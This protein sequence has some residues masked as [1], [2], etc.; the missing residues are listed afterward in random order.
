MIPRVPRSCCA[1][2]NYLRAKGALGNNDS[3]SGLFSEISK[4]SAA[5]STEK[6]W[7]LSCWH[8][9]GFRHLQVG[10][11][12]FSLGLWLQDRVVVALGLLQENLGCHQQD[13]LWFW[14]IGDGFDC[15]GACPWLESRALH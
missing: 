3:A 11:E 7:S 4:L 1:C 10:N 5:F 9:G 15:S 2:S 13:Q 6:S 12:G 8:L 14:L